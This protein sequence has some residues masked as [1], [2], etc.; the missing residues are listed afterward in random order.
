M[1]IKAIYPGTFDPVTNGHSDLIERAS[2]LFNEVIIGVASSPSK[3][4]RFTLEQRVEMIKKITQHIDN[5]TV[6]GFSG[7]LVDFAKHHQAKVLIRGLRAVS[8]FEYEFQLANMNRRL[9]PD[10]E[11]V[12]LTPAEGNSFISSTL[13]KE[14]ALHK[15]DVSQYTVYL[16]HGRL[17][18]YKQGESQVADYLEAGDE[19]ASVGI[20]A[21]NPRPYKVVAESDCKVLQIDTA[22][23]EKILCWGAVS[24][25]LL[26]AIAV[27]EAYADDYVW[28]KKLLQSSLFYK[29][30]PT[31]IYSILNRFTEVAF[32]KSDVIIK[33]G[34]EG[35]CCYLIKSGTAEV[36][37]NAMGEAAVATLSAGAVFGEDALVTQKTRNATIIM[38]EAGV[39]LKLEKHDFYQLLK[40]PELPMV[41]EGNVARLLESGAIL[42]DVRTQ[43]EYDAAHALDAVNM[44]L[45]LCLLKSALLDKSKRYICAASSQERAKAAAALLIGQ[46]FKAQA[47]QGAVQSF[48]KE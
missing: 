45:H 6:V 19:K 46:G 1:T 27:D 37:V 43:E 17:A 34:D 3:K 40:Q 7:L 24:R 30:P 35:S 33:E 11:S 20:A 41:T 26:A 4:P 48:F 8:D 36:F 15:G 9:S 32:A 44:P 10:L 14:V 38:A 25:A 12:F 42:L 5:V 22:F 21:E 18:L 47:L 31:N 16:L 39:L 28:I 13:V 29:I 23:M 2:L